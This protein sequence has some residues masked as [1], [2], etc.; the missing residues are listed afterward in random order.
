MKLIK[1]LFTFLRAIYRA[2]K[3]WWPS[4]VIIFR[5]LLKVVDWFRRRKKK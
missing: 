2:L 3:S 5:M 4:L 1:R